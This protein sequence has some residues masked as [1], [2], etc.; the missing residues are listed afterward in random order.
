MPVTLPDFQL[1]F[2]FFT[3]QEISFFDVKLHLTEIFNS[4]GW[5]FEFNNF[6]FIKRSFKGSQ[7]FNYVDHWANRQRVVFIGYL[8]LGP[9][10]NLGSD[11]CWKEIKSTAIKML[12]RKWLF[13]IAATWCVVVMREE[14]RL[15]THK[16]T[17][18]SSVLQ[19]VD[20]LWLSV[21]WVVYVA[22]I[23]MQ[24]MGE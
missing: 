16:T 22:R 9:L 17:R 8:W 2:A 3:R 18:E 12:H 19:T 13:K 11:S 7:N 5:G 21:A 15:W 10:Q 4:I 14:R 1:T 20:H 6:L 24:T 23:K